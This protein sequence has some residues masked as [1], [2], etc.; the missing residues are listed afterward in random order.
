MV[1]NYEPTEY[2]KKVLAARQALK[3]I[4]TFFGGKVKEN[5]PIGDSSI[6]DQYKEMRITPNNPED[7]QNVLLQ[8]QKIQ[9]DMINNP[10][11]YHKGEIDIYEIMQ[12][13]CTPEEYRGFCKGNILK[14]VLRESMKGGVEDLK[15]MR[16]NSERLI[17]SYEGIKYVPE[18]KK[19]QEDE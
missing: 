11:H 13:K 7:V 17:E 6:Q 8:E 1:N 14:Y 18:Y 10:H 2:E 9:Q 3:D 5:T 15:K 16:F 4:E 19:K 12:A